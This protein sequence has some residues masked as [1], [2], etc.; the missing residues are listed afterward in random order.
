MASGGSL[1][2]AESRCCSM[3]SKVASDYAQQNECS[4]LSSTDC[5][6]VRF[7]CRQFDFV[8]DPI[9]GEHAGF[10]SG[11]FGHSVGA[12]VVVRYDV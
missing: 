10:S 7:R 8:F 5:F 1:T 2:F 12:L 9:T 11:A 4:A 6:L 3:T